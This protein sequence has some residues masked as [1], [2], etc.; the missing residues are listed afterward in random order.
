MNINLQSIEL[1]FGMPMKNIQ[2]EY[3]TYDEMIIVKEMNIH[4]SLMTFLVSC[5]MHRQPDLVTFMAFTGIAAVQPPPW[6]LE[7]IN[8]TEMQAQTIER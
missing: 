3:C 8:L 4:L 1:M 6:I 5:I 7:A 2:H